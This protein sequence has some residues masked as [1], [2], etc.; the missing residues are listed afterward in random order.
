MFR[1]RKKVTLHLAM[2]YMM[3]KRNNREKKEKLQKSLLKLLTIITSITTN[4][5]RGSRFEAN[6][7]LIFYWR[8]STLKS[9]MKIIHKHNNDRVDE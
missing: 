5:T 9:I 4:I 1:F 8:T 2:T 6:R 7:I 3:N